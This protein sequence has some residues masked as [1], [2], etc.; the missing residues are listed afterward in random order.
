MKEKLRF[1]TISKV[2]LQEEEVIIQEVK[3]KLV[4]EET[5]SYVEFSICDM[6]LESISPSLKLRTLNTELKKVLP[7]PIT[8][9]HFDL[10]IEKAVQIEETKTLVTEVPKVRIIHEIPKITDILLTNYCIKELSLPVTI[11]ISKEVQTTAK[12]KNI[13]SSFDLNLESKLLPEQVRKLNTEVVSIEAE[14]GIESLRL[15]ER[16]TDLPIFEEF[17]KCDKRF[18]RSFS[19][20]S[21]SPFI[22]LIGEDEYE[23][24]IPIIYA[25]N[26]LFREIT[27][28]Y[29]RITFREPEDLEEVEERIDSLD[30]HSLEQFTFEHKIEFLDARRM[31]LAIDEF[32]GIVKGRLE[33]AFLQQFGILVI[34]VK[35]K[36]LK[37]AR[38]ALK[39]KGIR[40]YTCEPD[41]SKYKQ[42]C[43][44][45]LGIIPF[46]EFFSNLETYEKYL[47][48]TVR[49][50]SI[51]VKR[52]AEATDKLQYPLKVTTFVYLLNELRKRKKKL[53]S[54]FE[55]LC[56]FIKEVL[57]SKEIKVEEEVKGKAIIPD[58]TYSLEGKE[59]FIEIETLIGTFEP[60][61]K[62]DET[63]EKYDKDEA[64]NIWI[65]LKPISALLHY[66]ELKT[67]EKAYKA[68]Y[69]NKEI[70]FKVLTLLISKDKFKW[71]LMDLDDFLKGVRNVK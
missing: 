14:V 3:P 10:S 37:R 5:K 9:P 63:I 28:R 1:R 50:F 65:V 8:I 41:D 68:L 33:S 40:V 22:V 27:D 24:H 44:K 48:Q 61:K 60:M 67:R 53:I 45:V 11:K 46:E 18:P 66:E 17:I 2:R 62:I 15:T 4:K 64:T 30:P 43:S 55:E 31:R 58:L 6:L 21:N 26:E 7:K 52:G 12:I 57:D 32:V 59:S 56:K 69:E 20:S 51:F 47:D 39:V 34:A 70:T 49:R 25:L 23:W 36:D 71:K 38:E 35:R 42:F 19:E 29:P 16:E 13:T 54:N